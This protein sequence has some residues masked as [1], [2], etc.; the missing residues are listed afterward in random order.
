MHFFSPFNS[1]ECKKKYKKGV[2]AI[3]NPLQFHLLCKFPHR[4]IYYTSN[5]VVR[6]SNRNH[7]CWWIKQLLICYKPGSHSARLKMAPVNGDSTITKS[8]MD[9]IYCEH[10]KN[11]YPYW[12]LSSD[13]QNA[14]GAW[15]FSS[16]RHYRTRLGHYLDRNPNRISPIHLISYFN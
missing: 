16:R 2:Q 13:L 7:P 14:S 10:V 8:D 4:Q 11:S 6:L 3:D 1:F 5:P 15:N 12:N 9:N